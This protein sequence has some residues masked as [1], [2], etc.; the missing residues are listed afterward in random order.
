MK[1]PRHSWPVVRRCYGSGEVA[2]P[3]G[4]RDPVSGEPDGIE[5]RECRGCRDCR[6]V[7]RRRSFDERK[8]A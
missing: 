3:V 2:Q 7:S 4:Q 1:L 6:A 5:Y 8:A